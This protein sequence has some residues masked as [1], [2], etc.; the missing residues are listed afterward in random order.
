MLFSSL[1]LLSLSNFKEKL[2][3]VIKKPIIIVLIIMCSWIILSIL[4]NGVYNIY[5]VFLIAYFLVFCN[6]YIMDKKCLRIVLNTFLIIGA[7]SFILGMI[8][9]TNDVVPGFIVQAYPFSTHY[10]NPNHSAYVAAILA[11]VVYNYFN[12]STKVGHYIYYAVLYSVFSYF[13]FLN[14]TYSAIFAVFVVEFFEVVFIWIKFKKCP[15]KLLSLFILLFPLCFLSDIYPNIAN[16]RTCGYNFFLESFA[17]FD[18]IFGTDFLSLFGIDNIVGADGWDRNT[19]VSETFTHLTSSFHNFVFGAGAGTMYE[20]VPHNVLLSL[21]LDFGIVVPVC[22]VIILVLL[23]IKH[24]KSQF[25]LVNFAHISVVITYCIMMQ[26][27]N[28]FPCSF[29]YFVPFLSLSFRD[30]L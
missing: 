2:L 28:I 14:G 3:S 22:L 13:L 7:T 23:F 15:I 10:R 25:K 5:L 20:L 29:V 1:N 4:I 30:N 24:C 21:W 6:F 9:P 26:F 12:K 11:I 16:I 8:N 18:N 27:G 19:L 17:V